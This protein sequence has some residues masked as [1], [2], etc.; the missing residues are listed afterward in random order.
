MWHAL[1]GLALVARRRHIE[2]GLHYFQFWFFAWT[3]A[4]VKYSGVT[5]KDFDIESVAA[6]F[7]IGDIL[8]DN[9]AATADEPIPRAKIE[10]QLRET[11]AQLARV[12]QMRRVDSE[13]PAQEPV[14]N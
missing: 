6:D 10:A 4:L 5:D 8:P 3:N 11:Q 13:Q 1:R 7:A 2:G 12:I 9:Y 14:L